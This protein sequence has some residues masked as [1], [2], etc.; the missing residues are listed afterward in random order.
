MNRA[1]IRASTACQPG[2]QSAAGRGTS[3]PLRGRRILRSS[4]P[5]AL[6][7]A[8]TSCSTPPSGDPAASAKARDGR[9]QIRR[10]EK[11]LISNRKPHEFD[12][13]RFVR[14]LQDA[15]RPVEADALADY[16]E[17]TRRGE[18]T[19]R[20]FTKQQRT[21]CEDQRM[22]RRW[23]GARLQ[24][25]EYTRRVGRLT[26][27]FWVGSD[28]ELE[29]IRVIR[30]MDSG[31]AWIL[32][33]SIGEARVSKSR[34]RQMLEDNPAQFPLELCTSWNYDERKDGMP[35]GGSIRGY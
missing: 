7:L 23:G 33:D 6:L 24:P 25:D 3:N 28:A 12:Y 2:W 16:V 20:P 26:A 1:N 22:I 19:N 14:A 15:D 18:P 5:I 10:L 27:K 31:A 4:L 32:I 29:K 21:E 35:A 13:E 11:L 8:L 17:R 34:V 30:A 9:A